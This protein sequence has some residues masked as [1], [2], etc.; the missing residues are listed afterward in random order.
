LLLADPLQQQGIAALLLADPSLGQV[1]FSP[2][3]LDGAP[4]LVIWS[5]VAPPPAASLELELQRLFERW[6]PV[7]ILLV[8]PGG[9]G[10]SALP[11]LQLPVQGLLEAPATAPS[12]PSL[13]KA[14]E[15]ALPPSRGFPAPFAT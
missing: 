6:Q 7:P 9:H 15:E 11:L 1:V 2:G 13:Y 8:L 4:Q 14:L 3:D 5:L 12:T 10:Y